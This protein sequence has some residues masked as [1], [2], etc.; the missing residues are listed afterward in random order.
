MKRIILCIIV[1]ACMLSAAPAQ[2]I[3][4]QITLHDGREVT[5]EYAFLADDT[6]TFHVTGDGGKADWA[7]AYQ[8]MWR[9]TVIQARSKEASASFSIYADL[10]QDHIEYPTLWA[11]N[12]KP[13]EEK[14]DSSIYYKGVIYTLD[15]DEKTD[16]MVIKFN[17]LPSRPKITGVSFTQDCYDW[18]N[19]TFY[20]NSTFGITFSA[21]RCEDAL[22]ATESPRYTERPEKYTVDFF[23]HPEIRQEPNGMLSVE[24]NHTDWGEYYR[25]D[26]YNKYGIIT[27][28][29]FFLTTDYIT[30]PLILIRLKEIGQ[31]STTVQQAVADN[32]IRI[33]NKG[34]RIEIQGDKSAVS[35][36]TLHDGT[37]KVVKR[38]SHGEDMNISGLPQGLYILSCRTKDHR[39][40]TSKIIR[41]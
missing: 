16:S 12:A 32:E 38:Q 17:L 19:D 14:G 1:N 35:S 39:T 20:P 26:V 4:P 5:N 15:G 27:G 2:K 41:R 8:S 9:G 22:L 10:I 40:I 30:D 11:R 37:G 31:G 33:V 24:T 34:N 23:I 6:C 7:F 25:L 29:D 21:A 28:K 3:A 36:L 13:F 18:D